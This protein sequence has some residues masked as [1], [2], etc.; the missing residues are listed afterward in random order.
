MD[1]E[2]QGQ[3]GSSA[4]VVVST[5]TSWQSQDVTVAANFGPNNV[6]ASQT[7]GFAPLPPYDTQT[8][9]QAQDEIAMDIGSAPGL[10]SLE[11]NPDRKR[12]KIY[13]SLLAKANSSTTEHAVQGIIDMPIHSNGWYDNWF[14]RSCVCDYSGH[15]VIPEYIT[16][17]SLYR[18][19]GAVCLKTT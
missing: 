11:D 2:T 18:V 8:A 1:V 12:A 15:H 9:A 14:T 16:S 17:G 6:A 3:T 5:T 7:F 4:E 13:D 19:W 10:S